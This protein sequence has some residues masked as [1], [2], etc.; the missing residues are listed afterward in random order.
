MR[1]ISASR[2]AAADRLRRE[3]GMDAGTVDFFAIVLF[4]HGLR[5]GQ[6]RAAWT[7]VKA[8]VPVNGNHGPCKEK[9]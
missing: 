5:D 2:E 9:T 7:N 1:R 8:A 6:C 4:K 3:G